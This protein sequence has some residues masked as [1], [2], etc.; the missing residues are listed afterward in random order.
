MRQACT[1]RVLRAER[2]QYADRRIGETSVP[3]LQS[4]LSSSTGV[5]GGQV[6]TLGRADSFPE[7][8]TWGK[9]ERLVHPT[10][11]HRMPTLALPE[12]ADWR[13]G[14]WSRT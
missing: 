12:S 4:G 5:L 14:T 6:G 10:G 13:K 2:N 11:Q 8:G 7:L 1:Q 3:R 9:V